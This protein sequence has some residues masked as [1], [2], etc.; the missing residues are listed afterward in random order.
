VSR[1]TRIV[2]LYED[3]GHPEDF[4]PHEFVCACIADIKQELTPWQ[5]GKMVSAHPTNGNS[6]LLKTVSKDLERLRSRARHV[7]AV[8]DN[9]EVRRL[10]SLEADACRPE[11]LEAFAARI[12]NPEHLTIN[13]VEENTETILEKIADEMSGIDAETK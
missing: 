2:I 11:V 3:S 13:L 5:I 10:L 4:G 6:K 1:D 7:F 12:P 8:F 9:D